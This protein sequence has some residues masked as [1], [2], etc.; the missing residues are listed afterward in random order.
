MADLTINVWFG[1]QKDNNIVL[2][3]ATS[4]DNLLYINTDT[5]SFIFKN[6]SDIDIFGMSLKLEPANDASVVL[7]I[8][9]LSTPSDQGVVNLLH[10]SCRLTQKASSPF[11]VLFK[12]VDAWHPDEFICVTLTVSDH[13]KMTGKLRLIDFLDEPEPEPK[14]KPQ[15]KPILTKQKPKP[16]PIKNNS[17]AGLISLILIGFVIGAGVTYWYIKNKSENVTDT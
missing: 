1:G 15:P 16:I 5:M 4:L 2:E 14:P 8:L 7:K 17:K 9:K 10:E 3:K 12:Q 13:V 6:T 11:N